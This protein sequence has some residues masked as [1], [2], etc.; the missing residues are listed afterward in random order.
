MLSKSVTMCTDLFDNSSVKLGQVS[1][2]VAAAKNGQVSSK[3]AAAKNGQVSS[4][5]AAAKKR[6]S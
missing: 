6:L 4:K 2:N 5:L 1:S 3:F